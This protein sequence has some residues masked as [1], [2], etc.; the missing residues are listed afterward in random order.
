MPGVMRSEEGLEAPNQ[1]KYLVEAA[2]ERF[3]KIWTQLILGLEAR[4]NLCGVSERLGWSKSGAHNSHV[5]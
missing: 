5:R 1:P 2:D 3:D 4:A